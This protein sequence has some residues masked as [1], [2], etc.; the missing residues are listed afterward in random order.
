MKIDVEGAEMQVLRGSE[1]SLKAN[2]ISRIAAAVYH[3]PSEGQEVRDF[4]G[5][6]NYDVVLA[7]L[8]VGRYLY[9]TCNGAQ[10]RPTKPSLLKNS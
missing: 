6:F 10:A 9:A 4:L 8:S 3:Y 2:R 1:Q 7:D 5:K